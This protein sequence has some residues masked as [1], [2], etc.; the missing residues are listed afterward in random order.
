MRTR[1]G[2]ATCREHTRNARARRERSR[3][4]R[5]EGP[6]RAVSVYA[7]P[8]LVARV[9]RTIQDHGLVRPADRILVAVSGGPDSIALLHAL[10]AL[11]RPL[12]IEIEAATVDHGL[13]GGS[14]EEAVAVRTHVEGLGVRCEILGLAL[15]PGPG[16]Q[17]RARTA[18]YAALSGL[19]QARGLAAIAVGHTLDDQAETVLARLLRG[20]GVRGLAGA[21][22]RRED[23]VIRPLLDCDRAAVMSFL[24][25][26]GVAALVEDPTNCSPRFLRSRV[27]HQLLPALAVEQPA[28]RAMLARLADDAEAHRALAE[29]LAGPAEDA[30][31]IASLAA[32]AGPVRRER[33]RRWAQLHGVGALGRTNLEALERAVLTARGEVRLP[34]RLLASIEEGRLVAQ[35][36]V[37]SALAS[38]ARSTEVPGASRESDPPVEEA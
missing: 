22:R 37:V 1:R 17:A 8:V 21:L 29:S 34:N 11:R 38:T 31:Q 16:A 4:P 30:P 6:L 25:A 18:R 27:R 9:Q 23:G 10:A 35:R 7:G 32:A 24:A 5:I 19:A 20:A 28:I 36:T 15:A 14:L 2:V 3:V 26:R 33:L 13:R 12:G